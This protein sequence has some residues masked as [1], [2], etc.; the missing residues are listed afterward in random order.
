MKVWYDGKHITHLSKPTEHTAPRVSPVVNTLHITHLSKPTEHT[1]PRVSP[2][3]NY[4]LW[5]TVMGQC[6]PMGCNNPPRCRGMLMVGKAV[7]IGRG[8]WELSVL[9]AQACQELKTDLK[10]S[11][12]KNTHT[13]LWA[14]KS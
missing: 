9:C 6:K 7:P 2:V 3:V 1:A 10:N 8:M 11:L 12:L 5:G 13:G 14:W 4:G